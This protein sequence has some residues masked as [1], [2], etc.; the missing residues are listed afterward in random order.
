MIVNLTDRELDL[1]LDLLE[2]QIDTGSSP[3]T[4][5]DDCLPNLVVKLRE[6]DALR[7]FAAEALDPVEV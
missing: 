1:L 4:S 6:L 5:S 7:G 3:R 2:E